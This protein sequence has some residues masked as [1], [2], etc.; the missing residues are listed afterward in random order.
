MRYDVILFVAGGFL[1]GCARSPETFTVKDLQPQ[2]QKILEKRMYLGQHVLVKHPMPYGVQEGNSV[3]LYPD[4]EWRVMYRYESATQTDPPQ[5]QS[6]EDYN[7]QKSTTNKSSVETK[8]L[9]PSREVTRY[10]LI[11]LAVPYEP[12]PAGKVVVPVVREDGSV[13]GEMHLEREVVGSEHI[14]SPVPPAIK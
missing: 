9:D 8:Q 7:F 12:Q 6:V 14:S 13:A 1:A 11:G 4:G 2:D 10:E 3:I 5:I